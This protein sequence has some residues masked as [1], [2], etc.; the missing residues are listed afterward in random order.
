MPYLLSNVCPC[1]SKVG[2]FWGNT[3]FLSGKSVFLSRFPPYLYRKPPSCFLLLA[4]LITPPC[5]LGSLLFLLNWVSYLGI[6]LC[7]QGITYCA[8]K[9][10]SLSILAVPQCCLESSVFF[11]NHTSF[12][13]GF[14]LLFYFEFSAAVE[15]LLL[16]F[17][18][19]LICFLI[20]PFFL[21]R[22]FV[23]KSF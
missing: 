22:T 5:L 23:F 11:I 15:N 16:S 7:F 2:P 12:H 9:E 13:R 17:L 20:I 18:K 8:F 10:F 1:F 6:P 3:G 19:V 14:I 4:L 21:S